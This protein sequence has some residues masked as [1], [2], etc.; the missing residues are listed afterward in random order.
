MD[1]NLLAI[2][3]NNILYKVPNIVI[4]GQFFKLILQPLLGIKQR[5]LY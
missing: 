1:C 4:G 5:S 2:D 3:L